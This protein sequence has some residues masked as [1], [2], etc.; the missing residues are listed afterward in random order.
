MFLIN[1]ER[2][3][4]RPLLCFSSGPPTIST[5]ANK[6][7]I[8]ASCE[9]LRS[10][11]VCSFVQSVVKFFTIHL[12]IFILNVPILRWR[13]TRTETILRRCGGLTGSS[14]MVELILHV[15]AL[16]F[17]FRK[18]SRALLYGGWFVPFRLSARKTVSFKLA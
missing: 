4:I 11:T 1:G 13:G 7:D 2:K 5:G 15:I 10:G 14:L 3:Y 9:H 12:H 8:M 6:R 16:V 18:Y 17:G